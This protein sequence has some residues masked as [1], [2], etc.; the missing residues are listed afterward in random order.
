[1]AGALKENLATGA[2]RVLALIC[3]ATPRPPAVA[4]LRRWRC[5][6]PRPDAG[7]WPL[8]GHGTWFSLRPRGYPCDRGAGAVFSRCRGPRP[9]VA[10]CGS[11]SRCRA[12]VH[13]HRRRR[14]PPV[15]A[16]LS[17]GRHLGLHLDCLYITAISLQLAALASK[18]A[19]GCELWRRSAARPY[20]TAGATAAVRDRRSGRPRVATA[21]VKCFL[22]SVG[23]L[24]SHAAATA[25]ASFGG[26][27][28]E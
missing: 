14:T 21:A 27:R 5:R 13:F 28:R 25:P 10:G 26:S 2:A 1:M 16:V 20:P 3:F 7:R 6:P 24:R 8:W 23:I 19:R 18:A 4:T 9:A 17:V 22:P 11:R 15:P 12:A